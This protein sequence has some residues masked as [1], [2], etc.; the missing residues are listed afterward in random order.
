MNATSCFNALRHLR[1]GLRLRGRALVSGAL[2]ILL[3]GALLAADS[4]NRTEKSLRAVPNPRISVSNPAGGKVTI[5]G[6]DRSEVHAIYSTSSSKA[7]IEVDQVPASGELEKVHFVTNVLDAQAAP[8]EKT[9]SYELDVPVGSSIS[10]YNS[11]GSVTVERINGDEDVE[12][13]NGA[14]TVNDSS[15]HVSVRSINGD[16]NFARPSGRV[17]A[18]SVMGNLLFTGSTSPRVRAQTESGKIVFDGD[19]APTGEYVMRSWRGDMDVAVSPSDSFELSARTV[20]G[21]VDNQLHLNKRGHEPLS[22]G[23][24]LFGY[25]NQGDATVEL[26]SYSGT[27]HVRPR[28]N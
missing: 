18:T 9:A 28:S 23:E 26:K 24:G 10:V 11:E 4:G 25:H 15:G 7:A 13:I 12:S 17:E 20:N 3:P 22:H 27:I 16:I 21:K 2:L 19:F 6:W 1:C 14:V 8:Q 5:R